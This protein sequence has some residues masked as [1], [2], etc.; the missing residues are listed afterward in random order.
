MPAWKNWP[1]VMCTVPAVTITDPLQCLG[2][3]TW[4]DILGG[5]RCAG[6]NRLAFADALLVMT[7]RSRQ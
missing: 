4:F 6:A 1:T 3:P 5:E 7:T 2:A